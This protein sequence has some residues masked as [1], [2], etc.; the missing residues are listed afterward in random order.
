MA[1][2]KHAFHFDIE[3]EPRG[4][5]M[6]RDKK[7]AN[8]AAFEGVIDFCAPVAA[9]VDAPIVPRLHEAVCCG[10]INK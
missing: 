7:D 4:Q 8:G 3:N 5:R 9:A 2:F 10:R 6:A 1:P